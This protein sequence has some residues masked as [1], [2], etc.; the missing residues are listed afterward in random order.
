METVMMMMIEVANMGKMTQGTTGD[1]INGE[2]TQET[3][4]IEI[5][6]AEAEMTIGGAEMMIGGADQGVETTL[7]MNHLVMIDIE[8]D[9]DVDVGHVHIPGGEG[10]T[11]LKMHYWP[12]LGQILMQQNTSRYLTAD[13]L[14]C[15][16]IF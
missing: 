16:E 11:A 8:I 2:A 15:S 6:G 13:S 4:E 12:L 1:A 9:I 3:T 5:Q 10:I 14:D 7:E